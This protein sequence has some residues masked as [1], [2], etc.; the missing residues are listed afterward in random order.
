L[1]QVKAES[2][3]ELV[4]WDSTEG[5]T[6]TLPK[7]SDPAMKSVYIHAKE[8]GTYGLTASIPNGKET[9]V[10]ICLVTIGPR[11]PPLPP[12]QPTF[13][14][15]IDA[16]FHADAAT[17][18]QTNLLAA[19]YSKAATTTVQDQGLTTTA[20][21]LAEMQRAVKLLGLPPGS[22]QKTARV[23]AD[24]LNQSFSMNQPLDAAL[25]KKIAI[26]FGDVATALEGAK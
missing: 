16:A 6:I 23:V 26:A 25:R 9:R 7:T 21:L 2:G 14:D 19:L 18:D 11:P 5:L 10:A 20:A 22:L 15:K 13:Q 12:P 4:T 3:A 8:N 1:I 17:K 24:Y